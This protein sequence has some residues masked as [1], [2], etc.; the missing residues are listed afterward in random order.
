MNRDQVRCPTCRAVQDRTDT[1]RR[2]RC[3]LGLLNKVHGIHEIHRRTCLLEL[4]NGRLDRALGHALS[5]HVL[6]PGDDSKRLLALCALSRQEWSTALQLAQA[7]VDAS[8]PIR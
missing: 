3:D 1:C 8:G 2:C 5:C 4:K 6:E 7:A